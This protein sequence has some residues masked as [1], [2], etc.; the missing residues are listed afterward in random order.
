MTRF[1][2][3]VCRHLG[4]SIANVQVWLN[5]KSSA[6]RNDIKFVQDHDICFFTQ[7]V[8]STTGQIARTLRPVQLRNLG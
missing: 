2:G 8:R 7:W 4:F 5:L 3:Q 6:D 1:W